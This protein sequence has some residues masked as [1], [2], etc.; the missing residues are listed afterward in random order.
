MSY[1]TCTSDKEEV[2]N[3]V[4]DILQN[5]YHPNT[6]ILIY[7]DEDDGEWTIAKDKR[8]FSHGFKFEDKVAHL[9]KLI[10]MCHYQMLRIERMTNVYNIKGIVKDVAWELNDEMQKYKNNKIEWSE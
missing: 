7:F 4:K 8:F 2:S 3:I 1:Q 5:E 6:E 10:S 9:E